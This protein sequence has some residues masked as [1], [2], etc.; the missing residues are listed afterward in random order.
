MLKVSSITITWVAP[1]SVS[2][3]RPP[4]KRATRKAASST[5]RMRNSS[6]MSCSIM[7]RRRLRFW[8]LSRNSIAAQRRRLKRMRLMRWMRMGELTRAPPA[9]MYHG[10]KKNSIGR[11][12][13]RSNGAGVRPLAPGFTVST[14]GTAG[15]LGVADVHAVMQ[16][17]GQDRIEIIPGADQPIVDP[18]PRA[19]AA[20]LDQVFL[21]RFEI[22]VAQGTRI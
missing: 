12:P 1:E 5:R 13:Q 22:A 3:R 18:Q 11:R 6:R 9:T 15:P 4:T 8:D 14:H 7:S 10:C 17:L 20:D 21:Q 16:E 2:A 19:A